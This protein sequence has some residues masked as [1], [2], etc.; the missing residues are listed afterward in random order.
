MQV[1]TNILA[2]SSYP[3]LRISCTASHPLCDVKWAKK[4]GSTED[5]KKDFLKSTANFSGLAL[6]SQLLPSFS[7][8]FSS[9]LLILT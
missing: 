3:L 9:V 8:L 1:M 5:E 4:S 2:S 7:G 6:L